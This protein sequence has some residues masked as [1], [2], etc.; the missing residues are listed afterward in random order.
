MHS[1]RHGITMGNKTKAIQADSRI[2]QH[3]QVYSGMFKNYSGIL[4]HIQ[5]PV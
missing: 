5:N 4:R 1:S 3:I 2:L